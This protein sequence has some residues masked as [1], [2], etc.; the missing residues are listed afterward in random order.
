MSESTIPE[1]LVPAMQDRA[2][3]EAEKFRAE[4]RRADAE[5][6]AFAEEARTR[7]AQ[8]DVAEIT[9]HVTQHE[10]DKAKA[11]D[12]E[13]NIYRFVGPVA[14]ASVDSAMK[15]I[16]AWSRLNPGAP[17]EIQFYSPGGSVTAGFALWDF[18]MEIKGRDDGHRITTV[19][20]GYAAS[21]AG[22]LA[23]VGDHRVIGKES[24]LMIHE[25]SFGAQGKIGEVLDTAEW[26]KMVC[27]R[28]ADIFVKGSNGKLSKAKFQAM[29][30]RQD[31]W[32]SSD[33]ALKFGLVDEVR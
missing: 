21:M 2:A 28:V 24:W 10:F 1:A 22:I 12:K 30:S 18:L 6:E 17:L 29:W 7:R 20:N 11:A 23:Q 25:V 14:D 19:I 31:C 15:T 27:K 32:L 9:A 8:A 4:A 33:D 13:H 3:A 5:V 26:I 16:S